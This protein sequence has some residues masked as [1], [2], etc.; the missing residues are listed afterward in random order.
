MDVI[1]H[2][3]QIPV[4]I[5][6]VVSSLE[7]PI[8]RPEIVQE[9]NNVFWIGGYTCIKFAYG[10][11]RELQIPPGFFFLCLNISLNEGF[12]ILP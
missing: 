2:G 4:G 12:E 7:S 5:Q 9:G 3:R 8:D 1:N 6:V 11:V 10:N